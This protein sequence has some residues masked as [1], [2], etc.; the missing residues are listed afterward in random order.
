MGRH[1][2]RVGDLELVATCDDTFARQAE[3]LLAA[4]ASFHGKGKGLADGVTVQF[5]FSVLALRR[6]GNE[7]LVCEPDYGG[8]PFTQT[9]DDV[10][11]TLAV[12]TAQAAVVNRLGVEPVDVRFDDLV[13][14]ARGCLAERRV[15]LQR[16]EPKPGDSG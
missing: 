1:S 13:V 9:R 12:L 5:G 3:S 16:S 11:C 8:D 15:Y 2:R 4:V 14:A 10:T 6:R 7:L